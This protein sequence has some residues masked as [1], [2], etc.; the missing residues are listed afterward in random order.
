M[1]KEEVFLNE[2]EDICSVYPANSHWDVYHM[3]VPMRKF[4]IKRWNEKQRRAEATQ[5]NQA[6]PISEGERRQ[7]IDQ[8]QKNIE[9]NTFLDKPIR[10]Q[11]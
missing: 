1:S 6:P 10:N 9:K 11:K 3:P 8:A 2:I 5:N 4:Y 7:M